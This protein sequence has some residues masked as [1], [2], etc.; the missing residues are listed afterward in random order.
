[1]FPRFHLLY[2]MK[3]G[4]IVKVKEQISIRN[5]TEIVRTPFLVII[6]F[7]VVVLKSNFY[8]TPLPMLYQK[9][10]NTTEEVNIYI[11]YFNIQL[12]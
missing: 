11:I 1:M 12:Y 6:P 7:Y 8:H 3:F 10:I 4:M 5:C 2:F 9:I